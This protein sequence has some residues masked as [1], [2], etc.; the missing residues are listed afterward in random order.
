[1]LHRGLLCVILSVLCLSHTQAQAPYP[2]RTTWYLGALSTKTGE[3]LAGEMQFDWETNS[4]KIKQEETIKTFSPSNVAKFEFFDPNWKEQRH[5]V[6]L[7]FSKKGRYASP[8][9]FEILL[10]GKVSVLMR[11]NNVEA[12]GI[13]KFKNMTKTP[14]ECYLYT[15]GESPK[16]FDGRP[17]LLYQILPH[18]H[19][20]L[21]EFIERKRLNVYQLLDLIR[22]VDYYNS[23]ENAL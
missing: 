5:F 18:H 16:R 21:K 13:I 4:L 23:L 8:R 6:S 2:Y 17:K 12:V 3:E 20:D 11:E 15:E 7:P 19:A 1:M 14:S 10:E 22:V 9:F